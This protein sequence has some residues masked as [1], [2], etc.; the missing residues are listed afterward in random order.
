MLSGFELYPRWVPLFCE[1]L[2]L[3]GDHFRTKTFWVVIVECNMLFNFYRVHKYL[4][5]HLQLRKLV[6]KSAGVYVMSSIRSRW[7]KR[8]S[9]TSSMRPK[10]RDK[11][12]ETFSKSLKFWEIHSNMLFQ[13]SWVYLQVQNRWKRVSFCSSQKEQESVC[14]IPILY[15][16][17]FEAIFLWKNLNWNALSFDSL[18]HRDDR[19]YV[20]S[21]FT[22]ILR[23][24]CMSLSSNHFPWL[25]DGIQAFSFIRHS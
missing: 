22:I 15:R 25:L 8:R 4:Y 24:Q 6:P 9:F 5:I 19:Q 12:E 23:L 1:R 11:E 10:Q 7:W 16:K 2:F 14:L 13:K 18:V 21:Q 17:S 3:K 20:F